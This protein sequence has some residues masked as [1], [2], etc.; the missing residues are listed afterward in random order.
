MNDFIDDKLNLV[1]ELVAHKKSLAE[2]KTNNTMKLKDIL[3]KKESLVFDA[4][5]KS[6]QIR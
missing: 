4:N 5:K 3:E 1:G 2:T 6:H